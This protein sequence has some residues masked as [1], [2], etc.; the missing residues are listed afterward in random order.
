MSSNKASKTTATTGQV[1]KARKARKATFTVKTVDGVREFTPV[2][3]RAKA[4]A[5][6]LGVKALSSKHLK[7][8][9]KTGLRVYQYGE[10]NKLTAVKV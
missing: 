9:K 5:I 2:N 1:R 8:I 4:F 6:V 10:N 3:K 7:A